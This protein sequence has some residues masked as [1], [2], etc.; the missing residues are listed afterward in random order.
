MKGLLK[1]I[2]QLLLIWLAITVAILS[3]GAV[4]YVM[5]EAPVINHVGGFV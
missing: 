5:N 2:G 4:L 1:G 3:A